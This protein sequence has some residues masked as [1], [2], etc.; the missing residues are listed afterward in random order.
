MKKFISVLLSLLMVFSLCLSVSADDTSDVP[1]EV[2]SEEPTGESNE[3]LS[4]ESDVSLSDESTI[5]EGSVTAKNGSDIGGTNS[6]Y[7]IKNEGTATYDNVN[8]T[9]GN[10]D[11]KMFENWDSYEFGIAKINDVVYKTL[12]EA[13]TA[14]NEGDTVTLINDAQENI[15]I[16]K[17]ITLDLGGKTITNTNASGEA[18]ILINKDVSVT[19]KNGSVVGGTNSYYNIKNDG[20]ATFDDVNATAGNVDS[21]M[22]DNWGSLTIN[23]GNYIGGLNVIKSENGSKLEINGGYFELKK[24]LSDITGVI[25]SYGTT[26]INNGEFVNTGIGFGT[27]VVVAGVVEGYE[28]HVTINDGTFTNKNTKGGV[29]ILHGTG[30]ATSDNFTV[31]GGKYNKKIPEGYLETGLT[32]TQ[33]DGMYVIE[34]KPIIATIGDIEYYSLQDALDAALDGDT[35]VLQ[36]GL[37]IKYCGDALTIKNKKIT[38]DTNGNKISYLVSASK[39]KYKPLLTVSE[40]AEVEIIGNSEISGPSARYSQNYQG[41]HLIEVNN[42]S[43]KMSNS[44]IATSGKNNN[45]VL[46][47]CALNGANI[48]LTNVDI[49]AYSSI[50]DSNDSKVII[51]SGNYKSEASTVILDG[52]D[53]GNVEI[54]GGTFSSNVTKYLKDGFTQNTDGKVVEKTYVASIGD[55]KYETLNEAINESNDGDTI[56]VLSSVSL[57]K[58]LTLN[59]DITIDLGG[60][61][62]ESKGMLFDIYSKVTLKNGIF[63]GTEFAKAGATIWLNKKASLFVEKDATIDVTSNGTSSFDIGFWTDC[64]GATLTVNGTLKGENGVT[65]NG[66]IKTDNTVNI[67]GATIDVT[68]HGLYLAGV[69]TTNISNTNINAGSTAIEIRAGKLNIKDGTYT[70]AGEFKTS[71]NENGTTVDG[72][73]LAVSQ[74]TK[75]LPIDVTIDGGSFKGGYSLYEANVQENDEESLANVNIK[76]NDGNFDGKFFIENNAEKSIK[77]GNYSVDVS[78]YLISG[79]N[80]AKINDTYKVVNDGE[81]ISVT[82][83]IP[84]V[85]ET[86]YDEVKKVQSNSNGILLKTDLVNDLQ[87]NEKDMLNKQT[88][89][90]SKLDQIVPLDINLYSIDVNGVS[91]KITSLNSPITINMYLPDDIVDSIKNKTIKVARFHGGVLS[92]LDASLNG[93]I[94]TFKTDKFS[95]YAIV[96]YGAVTPTSNVADKKAGP[97]DLNSDG[98]IT[99]DEEMGSKNWIWSE[100][101]G[102]CVYKVSNTSVK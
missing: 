72:A 37:T 84:T 65:V 46:A 38:L 94:L 87:S 23:S 75:K 49:E 11:S 7:N 10:A 15:V 71:P 67:D 89:S 63:R 40:N 2:P 91:T 98:I 99:C 55:K 60:N 3:D 95:T 92:M 13:I 97:K 57:N 18:T 100:S 85:D 82:S 62:I 77:G 76:I 88:T 26:T 12:K 83:P 96:A 51:E 9:A 101:K 86:T 44:H 53:S 50:I 80:V 59:K 56:K 21:S 41:L 36:K 45:G 25:F 79:Y 42:A 43:L 66:M 6:S 19:V 69:A 22:F 5:K 74:H 24:G 30:K 4:G 17:N 54:S 32:C 28:S 34:K 20:T 81:K 16:D 14:A 90:N 78:K 48:T 39:K 29:T 73:A 31:R 102:S 93:N 1:L 47:L 35:V 58:G 70:S 64:D 8:A 52:I 33:K 61:T 68:G 27:K